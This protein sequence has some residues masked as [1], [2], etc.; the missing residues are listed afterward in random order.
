MEWKPENK[1]KN[2]ENV[3]KEIFSTEKTLVWRTKQI[4]QEQDDGLEKWLS[5]D[6]T[7]V[8]AVRKNYKAHRFLRL[9]YI[10]QWQARD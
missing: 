2:S 3:G 4:F 7:D 1:A 6:N 10:V 9:I 5:T 8:S